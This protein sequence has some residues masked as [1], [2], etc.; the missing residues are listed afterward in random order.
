MQIAY[1]RRDYE[2][3]T[4]NFG[5]SEEI[6]NVRIEHV[7]SHT[8]NRGNEAADKLASRGADIEEGH[9]VVERDSAEPPPTQ[10]ERAQR[11]WLKTAARYR[12]G[13]G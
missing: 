1:W 9:R 12:V 11:Q 5:K 8:G 7:R 2:A 13:V 3:R 10:E 6:N 4:D